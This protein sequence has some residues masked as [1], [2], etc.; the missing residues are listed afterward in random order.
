MTTD[1]PIADRQ[2]NSAGAAPVVSVIVP[3]WN[4]HD[5]IGA[6]LDALMRQDA[7]AGSFEVIVVDNGSTDA[8]PAIVARYPCVTLLSETRPSSYIARNTGLKVA[9]GVAIL[10]TDADCIPVDGWV[11]AALDALATMP[12]KGIYGGRIT[13]YRPPQGEEATFRFDELFE[14]NQE[15]R[16]Q[17]NRCVTANWMS[18]RA[19]LMREGG[20]DETLKS[21]G[22]SE[23]SRRMHAKG[24]EVV[25]LPRMEVRHPAR[26]SMAELV[27][28]RRR[29]VG[30]RW[31]EERSTAASAVVWLKS[32]SVEAA[33]DMRRVCRARLPWRT[34]IDVGLAVAR[35][36]MTSIGEV[37]RLAVG[38]E[39]TRA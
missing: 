38:R 27:R 13:M 32:Y 18:Y 15:R 19:D 25:Y 29:I 35:L 4:G 33:G 3:V 36:W 9:R 39:A 14:L 2:A 31:Q 37:G 8:T 7:P 26:S 10:F 11:S 24:A 23:M 34:K 22:D 28:K 1:I 12:G 21:C 20:F 17:V 30:G 5:T 16:T 6:C